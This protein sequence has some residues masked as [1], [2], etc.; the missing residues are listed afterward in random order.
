MNIFKRFQ[1]LILGHKPLQLI[2]DDFPRIYSPILKFQT[3]A[4][5][6]YAGGKS[7]PLRYQMLAVPFHAKVELCN[8]C[9]I[10]YWSSHD[11]NGYLCD[12]ADVPGLAQFN[13]SY[14]RLVWEKYERK[15][16]FVAQKLYGQYLM[17]LKLAADNE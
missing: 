11:R 7:E 3:I 16:N 13:D 10:L 4:H 1:C 2:Q 8:R 14:N 9:K 12:I 17:A 15:K 5:I 6:G